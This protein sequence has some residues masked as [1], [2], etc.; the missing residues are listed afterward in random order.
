[1]WTTLHDRARDC[2]A[3]FV[4]AGDLSFDIGANIGSRTQVFRAL[5][6]R[7][8]AV[9]PQP[10]CLKT[11]RRVFRSDRQ[12]AIEPCAVGDEPG[13]AELFIGSAHVLSTLSRD[14]ISATRQSGRLATSQWKTSI[15][16][17]VT[18]LDA[19]IEKHGRPAFAKI[20]VEGFE[21]SV[22][23]GLSVPI[24]ALSLEFTPEYLAGTFECLSRLDALAP[25]T[26]NYSLGESMTMALPA[27]AGRDELVERLSAFANDTSIIGDVYVRMHSHA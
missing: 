23:R 9:E 14:W 6:A 15:R 11:L 17:P 3:Q 24:S 8:V 21:A 13:E 20:D 7:V 18:T 16:V 2:Y 12:V 26:G 4:S 19:L 1:M 25:I 27:W 5:G 10:A 22:I